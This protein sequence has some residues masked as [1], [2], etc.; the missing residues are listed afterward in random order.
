M[1][2]ISIQPQ[3]VG[4]PF[5]GTDRN[6]I[7][8]APGHTSFGSFLRLLWFP[9]RPAFCRDG[10]FLFRR[11]D[12]TDSFRG[13]TNRLVPKRHHPTGILMQA[14]SREARLGR[15]GEPDQRPQANLL[16]DWCWLFLVRAPAESDRP[17]CWSFRLVPDRSQA[18]SCPRLDRRTRHYRY[19]NRLQ[20]PAQLRP[21]SSFSPRPACRDTL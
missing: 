13:R 12:R 11:A 20:L 14:R 18:P 2:L 16:S 19:R 1:A 6:Q 10:H 17:K 15:V 9:N 7:G 3:D 4:L 8:E 5:K 21:T